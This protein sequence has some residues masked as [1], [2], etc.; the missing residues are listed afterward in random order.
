MSIEI[1]SIT[2]KILSRP[3]LNLTGVR[4]QSITAYELGMI[5]EKMV[6]CLAKTSTTRT[7]YQWY[8][9]ATIYTHS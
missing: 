7:I 9:Y 2:I 4:I 8:N 3:N 6:G 1:K 5:L